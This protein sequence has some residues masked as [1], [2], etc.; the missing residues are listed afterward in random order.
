[1]SRL[2]IFASAISGN[3]TFN[4]L[5]I[6]GCQLWLDAADTATISVSGSEV[7]QWNDKSGNSRNFTQS[8]AANRPLSGTRSQNGKNIIDFDGSNDRLGSSAASSNWVFMHNG[9]EHTVFWA[10][11]KD[12]D[13]FGDLMGDNGNTSSNVGTVFSEANSYRIAQY[14]TRG[15]SGNTVIENYT[16]SNL[17]SGFH[18]TTVRAKPNDGTAA[19]RSEIFYN[20]GSAI[21]NNA[22]SN[23]P[24]SSNPTYNLG[25]GD[26]RADASVIP[27]N[28]GIGEILIYNSYLSDVDRDKVRTYLATKWGV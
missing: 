18:Y 24:S 21:K 2:G 11:V 16:G 23:A 8:T 27:F 10:C 13:T 28:G 19:N 4:P 14:V 25:V 6:S 1:M 17:T 15:V 7:T 3:L 26:S 22:Q 5:S 9:T 20:N 12:G